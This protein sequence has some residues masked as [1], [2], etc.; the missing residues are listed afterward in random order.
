VNWLVLA[1]AHHR[2]GHGEEARQ[3]FDK[4]VKMVD[5]NR[6]ETPEG[7]PTRP[8]MHP[9]DWMAW[10]LLRREAEALINGTSK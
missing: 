10:L 1:M 8:D 3:W 4:A 5:K 9:H 6:E 2:L 7:A